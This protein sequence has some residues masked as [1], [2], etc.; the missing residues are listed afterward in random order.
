[1]SSWIERGITAL[2]LAAMLLLGSP[3]ASSDPR[4]VRINE[5]RGVGPFDW[6]D[7]SDSVRQMLHVVERAHFTRE[8]LRGALNGDTSTAT[9]VVRN[10]DYTLRAFPNHPRALMAMGVF[11]TEVKKL[12][13]EA[14]RSIQNHHR[15]A[16][17][18]CYF[19]RA[20]TLMPGDP[21]I[22]NARGIVLSRA[23]RWDEAI[24][25]FRRAVE[26]AP[27][28]AEAHYNLGL[29]YYGAGQYQK[30][31]DSARTAYGLGFRKTGLMQRLKRR[32]AW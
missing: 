22:H 20:L 16:P 26:L 14:W 5:G 13:P 24:E 9:G 21:G 15:F 6:R 10:L 8:H 3:D 12:Q 2:A 1:M 18:G 19:E 31:A 23:Q 7:K 29:A 4:C 28:S 11:Q 27:N 17:V 25:A 32:G 30:S